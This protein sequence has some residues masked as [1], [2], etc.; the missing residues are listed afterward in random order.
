M[1]AIRMSALG[2]LSRR[3]FVS[4]LAVLGGALLGLGGC[5]GGEPAASGRWAGRALLVATAGGALRQALWRHAFAPF[6]RETGC[7]VLDLT[8]PDLVAP[9]GRQALAGQPQW[10]VVALDATLVG[11]LGSD[12]VIDEIDYGRL[13]RGALGPG[14]ALDHA[15][16][17]LLDALAVGYRT[18]RPTAA[19]ADW[20]AVCD[21]RTFPGQRAFPRQAGGLLE[22]ALVA[23]GVAREHLYPLDVDRAL[24]ALE[25]ARPA[26]GAWW[27]KPRQPGELLTLGEVD[28]AVARRDELADAI[29]GGAT[30][31]IAPLA[32]PLLATAWALPRGGRD[33]DVAY[34]FLAYTLQPDV[35]AA[36]AREGYVPSVPAA[37][38]LL[39]PAE[40]A[41]LPD[42]PGGDVIAL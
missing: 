36:L 38:E 16:G 19:P 13:E 31:S 32:T 29:R 24:R 21:A 15:V 11:A 7:R 33:R 41:A 9:L 28:L 40:S 23:D 22:A 37:R 1:A 8:R 34:D 39:D 6:E 3:R 5:R 30:A 10:D 25:R 20:A 42:A 12:G 14:L 2:K 35:Q 4:R 17:V 26:V 27:E 18:D